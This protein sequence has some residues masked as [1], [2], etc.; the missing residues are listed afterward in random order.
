[1]I[2]FSNPSPGQKTQMQP[3]LNHNVEKSIKP[4]SIGLLQ[5]VHPSNTP[6]ISGLCVYTSKVNSV[7]F[8]G[9]NTPVT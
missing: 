1:M 5:F 9:V 8:T 2:Q 7:N 4:K 3:N 6:V